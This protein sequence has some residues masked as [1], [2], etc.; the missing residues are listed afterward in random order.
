[1]F[2]NFVVVGVILLISIFFTSYFMD[3]NSNFY[4]S[5]KQPSFQPP[6]LVFSV[7]WTI[8]YIILLYTISVSYPRNNK[9]L[10]Y[11]IFLSFLLVLWSFVF[12]RV[13]NLWGA[14]LVL[15]FTLFVS[16]VLWK[17]IV[18]VSQNQDAAGGSLALPPTLFLFFIAWI[19][20]ATLLNFNI[21]LNNK[22]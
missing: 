12:F 4:K 8:L 19:L 20:I 11:F 1:M 9:I 10:Y 13:Q 5:I 22:N 21:A 16:L 17:N 6:P 2:V 18:K 14:T 15:V 7:V 3:F